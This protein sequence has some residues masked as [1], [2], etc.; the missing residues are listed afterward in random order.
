MKGKRIKQIN[1]LT[2]RYTEA[3]QYA[4]WTPDGRCLEDRMTLGQPEE[5]CR[6]TKDFINFTK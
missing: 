5:F 6:Q 1:N 4:A 2:I 3:Y